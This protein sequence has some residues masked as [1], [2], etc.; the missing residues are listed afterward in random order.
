MSDYIRT[1]NGPARVDNS[2]PVDYTR[3]YKGPG[4]GEDMLGVLGALSDQ[5]SGGVRGAAKATLGAPGDLMQLI[6]HLRPDNRIEGALPAIGMGPG[7]PYTVR[8]G[9]PTEV[10]FDLPTSEDFER[11]LPQ[12]TRFSSNEKQP[13][14]SISQYAP[15]TPGQVGR[16][17]KPAGALTKGALAMLGESMA[18]KA[19]TVV[20]AGQLGAFRLPGGN[21]DEKSVER[22]LE[23]AGWDKYVEHG[24]ELPANDWLGKQMRNYLM[25]DFGST[26]DPLLQVEKEGRLHLTP[27]QLNAAET[28]LPD[29]D[30][31]LAAHSKLSGEPL[32]AWG[33]VGHDST[34]TQPLSKVLGR[35]NPTSPVPSWMLKVDPTTP[36]HQIETNNPSELGHIAD[37]VREAIGASRNLGHAGSIEELTKMAAEPNAHPDWAK[38]LELHNAGLALSP[39][40]LSKTSVA[41]AARKTSDWNKL[42]A[43]KMANAEA[44]GLGNASITTHKEYPE[45]GMRWVRIGG[46]NKDELAAALNAEGNSMGHCVGGYCDDVAD[47]GV[48]IF[49]LRDAKNRPHVTVEIKPGVAK[50][51]TSWFYAQAPELRRELG[52]APENT[53]FAE[54]EAWRA[55]ISESPQYKAYAEVV[56]PRIAQIKGKQNSAPIKE[57]QPYVQDF[58]KS[59][60]WS[61][62]SD[63]DNA[64]F[65]PGEYTPP[66]FAEGGSVAAKI[67]LRA[68]LAA[69]SA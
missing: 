9:L 31:A 3:R 8:T 28:W 67:A 43:E 58:I 37:Y 42:L 18:A 47:R 68:K 52:H 19:P 6:G 57:Y 34:Y 1:P 64:G 26:N 66:G 24:T 2:A 56:Q 27:E 61:G 33:R 69:R 17:V 23:N 48:Q 10:L 60:N 13:Q 22:V 25:K 5:L 50:S 62:V 63:L 7:T 39:E 16:L 15:L 35:W 41:D 45:Q 30:Y 54:N 65:T 38:A 14:E 59:G 11:W 21:M 51:P 46:E 12:G 40:Q 29:P 49:S 20:P 36:M 55:K 53:N 4:F 32:T 44:K